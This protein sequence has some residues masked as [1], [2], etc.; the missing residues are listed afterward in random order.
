MQAIQL[1][2]PYRLFYLHPFK[3]HQE[4]SWVLGSIHSHFDGCC[5]V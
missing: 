3:V 5:Q 4:D 2:I 1:L